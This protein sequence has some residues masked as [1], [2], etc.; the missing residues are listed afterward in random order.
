MAVTGV[1]TAGR[2]AAAEALRPGGWP[3]DHQRTRVLLV[4]GRWRLRPWPISASGNRRR[5]AKICPDRP[6]GAVSTASSAHP[7]S[8]PTLIPELSSR[9][10]VLPTRW[11]GCCR[12]AR[13]CGRCTRI[14]TR[15][16]VSTPQTQ[17]TRQP[18]DNGEF[19]IGT[20]CISSTA[21]TISNRRCTQSLIKANSSVAQRSIVVLK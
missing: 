7:V 3:N 19:Q 21:D 15:L 18:C 4:A 14:P 9:I 17:A 8:T 12:T 2:S 1:I 10:T 5:G 11:T 13:S 6:R 20:T 16:A